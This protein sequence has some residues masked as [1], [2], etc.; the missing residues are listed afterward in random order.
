[1]SASVKFN[2]RGFKQLQ[3]LLP[4]AAARAINRSA[5]SARA[6]GAR[7][8][9]VETGVRVRRVRSATTFRKATAAKP[10]AELEPRPRPIPLI[11]FGARGPEP[12]R[13]KGPGVRYRLAGRPVQLPHAFIA[14][15]RSG[16]R[17]VFTRTLPSTKPSPGAWSKNLPIREETLTLL[18][19]FR[20]ARPA[21]LR[22]F[23]QVIETHLT[24]EVAFALSRL[25]K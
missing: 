8:I 18:A 20:R 10:V 19:P 14:R 22:R 24:H 1:M 21:M 3:R 23:D 9:A 11:E 13:G 4:A 12:S 25:K 7:A 2:L 6:V 15:M 5:V 16:H 17:G